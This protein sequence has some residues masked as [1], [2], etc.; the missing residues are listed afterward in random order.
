MV[1]IAHAGNVLVPA[2][3]VLCA[4]GYRVSRTILGAEQMELWHA[5]KDGEHFTAPDTLAL[6][7]LVALYETRGESWQVDD[8]QIDE[9]LRQFP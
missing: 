2:Y 7:G 1:R 3:V 4:K 9:F 5:E 8:A 6:L